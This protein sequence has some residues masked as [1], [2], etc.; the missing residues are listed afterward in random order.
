MG[1]LDGKTTDT[2]SW[3]REVVY[4]TPG[5]FETM[6]IPIL[7]GHAIREADTAENAKIAIVS[8]SF[9]RKFFVNGDAVGHRLSM[10]RIPRE[11]VGIVGDV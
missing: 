9:S 6:R 2:R 5:Y 8:Q 7:Q 4:V 3:S 10:N 1:V 11:I